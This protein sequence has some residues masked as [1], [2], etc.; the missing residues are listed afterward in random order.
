VV[1]GEDLRNVRACDDN[2]DIIVIQLGVGVGAMVA[3]MVAVE[4]MRVTNCACT[5]GGEG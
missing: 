5:V 1:L 3:G 4:A 2:G